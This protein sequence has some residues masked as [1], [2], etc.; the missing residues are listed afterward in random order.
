MSNLRHRPFGAFVAVVVGIAATL[1]SGTAAS[2]YAIQLAA[3]P[4]LDPA[5]MVETVAALRKD[6]NIS[7][8]EAMRRLEL[9]RT[10][11]ALEEALYKAQP[12]TYGGMW[13]DQ[14]AGGTL[15]VRATDVDVVRSAVREVPDAIHIRVVQANHSRR[16]LEAAA[17]RIMA[18][19]GKVER[20]MTATGQ[21]EIDFDVVATVDDVRNVVAVQGPRAAKYTARGIEGA[22]G[23][24]AGTVLVDTFWPKLTEGACHIVGCVPP[25]RGGIKAWRHT[26][27]S[28]L[29]TT[30]YCTTGFNL[31]GNGWQWSITAGHCL[32]G[33][34]NYTRNAG[35]WIGAERADTFVGDYYP[36]DGAIMPYVVTPT[37]N[38][39]EYWLPSSFARNAVFNTG[40]TSMFGISK[41][42]THDQIK[43]GWAACHTGAGYN[44]TRCGTVRD[45]TSGIAMSFLTQGGDSGGPLFSQVD[46]SAYGINQGYGVNWSYYS[47]ISVLLNR[48]FALSGITFRVNFS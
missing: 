19:E 10:S 18:V 43:V 24:A 46:H 38:Y 33:S 15:V 42:Y 25:M 20:R 8:G 35:E 7:V 1:V 36:Y 41:M 28:S 39:A 5:D 40:V 21:P 6:Y 32:R 3:Q 11:A 26:S 45:K 22:R 30:A 48:A 17:A 13:L 37:R 27:L 34:Y 14:A 9:Q 29:S 12:D 4:A 44:G 31:N 23:L 16:A 2:A 47:P